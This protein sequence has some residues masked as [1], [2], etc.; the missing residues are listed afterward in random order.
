MVSEPTVHTIAAEPATARLNGALPAQ[1][2]V[3][4]ARTEQR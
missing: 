1:S 3:A 4:A 2:G